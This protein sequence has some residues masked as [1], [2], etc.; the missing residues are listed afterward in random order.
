M[1]VTMPALTTPP[2]AFLSHAW[3]DKPLAGALA[4]ALQANGIDT[5]YDAWE[6]GAGD[7]LRRKI[8]EGIGGCT[9]FLVLLTPSSITKEWVNQEMDAGLVQKVKLQ[10]RFIPVRSNLPVSALPPLI[11]GL[12]SPAIDDFNEGVRQL[13][14]DIHDISRKPSL[15]PVPVPKELPLTGFSPAANAVAQQFVM[16]SEGALFGDFQPDAEEVASRSGLS[17]ED[18]HDAVHELDNFF[19]PAGDRAFLAKAELFVEFDRCFRDWNPADDALRL[20][21]DLLN[22]ETFPQAASE[23]AE[24]YGWPARRLNPALAYLAFFKKRPTSNRIVFV[25]G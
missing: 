3:E 9:H 7:S 1:G 4:Q 16:G 17:L 2:R 10:A 20:A 11:S 5:W 24:R 23:I 19:T 15:G 6:I 13:V 8:D 22:D 25:T 12:M 18:V 14:N 21:Q